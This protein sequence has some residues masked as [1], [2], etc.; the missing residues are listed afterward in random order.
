MINCVVNYLKNKTRLL[1]TNSFEYLYLID[2]I[3]LLKEGKIIFNGDYG[4]FQ[5]ENIFMNLSKNIDI[6]KENN[7]N[8]KLT[9]EEN[10]EIGRIKLF[11]LF[12]YNTYAKYMGRRIFLFIVF[13]MMCAQYAT[14]C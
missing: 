7:L 8:K 4:Q 6:K 1:V 9:L 13:I 2:R 14:K 3:I 5:K 11:V 10:E 12:V